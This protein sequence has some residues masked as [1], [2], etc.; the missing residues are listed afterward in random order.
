MC[1]KLDF[2]FSLLYTLS[3]VHLS[4]GPMIPISSFLT[5]YHVIAFHDLFQPVYVY[6]AF[7][8]VNL[9][10]V[11]GSRSLFSLSCSPSSSFEPG[12]AIC[13]PSLT[14]RHKTK[15]LF[16]YQTKLQ[17]RIC[18]RDYGCADLKTWV[19]EVPNANSAKSRETDRTLDT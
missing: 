3:S 10:W 12:L 2:V 11:P 17:A 4:R 13:R 1:P 7:L 15:E 5:T 14:R 9:E 16:I 18:E 19:Q 8:S 6:T